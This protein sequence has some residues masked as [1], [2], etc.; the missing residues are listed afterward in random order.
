MR[1]IFFI[2][3]LL[4]FT[5]H[6]KVYDLSDPNVSLCNGSLVGNI[7]QCVGNLTL[8]KNDAIIVSDLNL[9][10]VELISSGTM[11]LNSNKIG[12]EEQSIH[13]KSLGG[14]VII[15]GNGNVIYGFIVGQS[16]V[17][18]KKVTVFGNIISVGGE[19]VVEESGNHITGS[20]FAQSSVKLKK[21]KVIGDI[22]SYGEGIFIEESGNQVFGDIVAHHDAKLKKVLVCG[23][24]TSEGGEVIIEENGNKIY[25]GIN[26][27]DSFGKVT[28]KGADVCGTVTSLSGETDFSKAKLYCGLNDA[29]CNDFS[30]CPVSP[31][32]DICNISPPSDNYILTITP[33]EQYSLVCN[34]V[35][36]NVLVMTDS[37]IPTPVIG[38]EI[39]LQFD[40]SKLALLSSN[41]VTDNNGEVKLSFSKLDKQKIE[42]IAVKA[43]LQG[44]SN[45]TDEGEVHYVPYM[46]DTSSTK[47]IANLSHS[48]EI[49]V[50][51]CDNN[52]VDIT[53][54]YEGKKLLD[55]STYK[56]IKPNSNDGIRTDFQ[57][58]DQTNPSKIELIFDKGKATTNLTYQE[59]GEV[60]FILSDPSFI[61]P[62]NFD[63]ND[64]PVDSDLLST[65]I[66][67]ESRPWKL[68]VCSGVPINGNSDDDSSSALVA[69]GEPFSLQVKP[70]RYGNNADVCQ[71]P[72]TQNF[73]A[74]TAPTATI[75]ALDPTLDSPAGGVLG[76][77]LLLSSSFEH[78]DHVTGI[79]ETGEPD[80]YYL[81]ENMTYDE[82]G[83][84]QFNVE[85][86]SIGFYD[87]IQ[88]GI[89]DGSSAVGRFYPTYFEI[90]DTIWDYPGN[91]GSVSG[92]Y[93]YMDQ[94]FTDVSFEV[95]AYN[96]SGT[97]TENYG[98]FSDGLKAS[99]SL[100]DLSSGEHSERLNITDADLDVSLWNSGSL[101]KV[102]GLGDTVT[103]KKKQITDGAS[104]LLTKE[105]GPFNM[106]G[107]SNSVTTALGLKISGVDPV[108]FDSTSFS[109]AVADQELLSQP[110]VRYGRMVLDSVGTAVGQDVAVPLRVQYWNGNTFVLSNTDNAS[111][112]E[113]G[114][115]CKQTVWPDPTQSSSTSLKGSNTVIQGSDVTNLVAEANNSSLREQVRFWLR[116]ASTSPQ[117]SETN[118]ACESG[119]VGQPWLQYNWR[120]QGD[121]DPSTVVTFG[122]FRGND[123]VIF[124]GESNI[125]GTS[126]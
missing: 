125:I 107:N 34:D 7:Y 67:I 20:I 112:F 25:A 65:T 123:R 41:L 51:A 39:A 13:L 59:A 96:S 40:Q 49:K 35:E 16:N 18:L 6:A 53:K 99:F 71:L 87:G 54:N 92:R 100:V 29:N 68:V 109:S 37:D 121:E 124:R 5:A 4:S 95:R 31:S 12:T 36:F 91:Q 105:D 15:E 94:N 97:E 110:D 122:I 9:T 66:N 60:S 57:L 73:F 81:F 21:T 75:V 46:F 98:L 63:C 126:N 30:N 69:A 64:Y 62:P 114:E 70:V 104:P 84:I 101:W 42:T 1:K 77:L 80:K 45:V 86:S 119:Y 103:W 3:L 58:A 24:I 116:L 33:V 43:S 11:K 32:D 113:G 89:P 108:S 56:L 102:T 47:V 55:V 90:T 38:K 8:Q 93:I 83:S 111:K 44:D 48:F 78:D 118:V 76:S 82:V 19:V 115:H 79:S 14:E 10:N 72:I 28:I 50:L 26:A 27:I 17:K 117:T 74:S 23:T 2:F 88:G 106:S 61:C 120:G 22:T 85:V 52:N